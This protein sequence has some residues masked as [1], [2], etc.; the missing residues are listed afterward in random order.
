M[1]PT[2]TS[3]LIGHDPKKLNSLSNVLYN[4][5][6]CIFVVINLEAISKQMEFHP[7]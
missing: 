3:K 5:F 6:L 1:C 2:V 4:T 7:A